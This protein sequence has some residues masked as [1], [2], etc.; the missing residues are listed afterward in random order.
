[1]AEAFK[2][3]LALH[4]IQ[5]LAQAIEGQDPQFDCAAYIDLLAQSA[6]QD[7]SLMERLRRAA[8]ALVEQLSADGGPE[9]LVATLQ[10][11]AQLSGWLSLICCEY[12]SRCALAD[13]AQALHYLS[14]MTEYFS[15]EFAI[16]PIIRRDPEV[17]LKILNEWTQHENH[18]VRRL[19]SEGTR[20]RLPWGIRLHEFIEQP[21]LVLP[22]LHAL[23]D[24]PE[25]YVRR[26]VANH[27][28]DLAK[29]HVPLVIDISR[30]WLQDVPAVHRI[31][32]QK[33]VRH[34]CRT[35]FKQGN[36]EV[37]QLF[38]Y[39]PVDDV[40]CDLQ[41]K[42]KQVCWQ[43][44]FEFELTLEKQSARENKLMVDYKVHFMKANGKQAAKVF[45]WLDRT[46]SDAVALSFEKKHSFKTV[47]TRKHYPGL[48]RLEVF[49]N[50]IKKAQTEFE[51]LAD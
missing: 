12:I 20:P 35:L 36:P 7:L 39:H 41:V 49:V 5:L 15:A 40:C 18:H 24:D 34:A 42:N 17:C 37:L 46:E 21:D 33:L 4:N 6:W 2:E 16:R 30:H 3:T 28:N 14:Q 13:S 9:L 26:S 25:E 44:D 8:E 23:R 11:N 47:T 29:D 22:L 10:N 32:R 38:G 50:G 19:V 43:G 1:M 27:L 48:H 45:K 51:L 31:N